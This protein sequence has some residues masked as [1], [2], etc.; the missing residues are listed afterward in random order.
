MRVL[1]KAVQIVDLLATSRQGLRLKEVADN[2]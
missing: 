1:N 2:L